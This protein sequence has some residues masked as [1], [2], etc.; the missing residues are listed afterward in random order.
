M[1]RLASLISSERIGTLCDQLRDDVRSAALRGDVER[2]RAIVCCQ[3]HVDAQ[4]DEAVHQLRAPAAARSVKQCARCS[5]V[6]VLDVDPFLRQERLDLVLVPI[7]A[8]RVKELIV[9]QRW[10]QHLAESPIVEEGKHGTQLVWDVAR[11][12]TEKE[13]DF[14]I[15]G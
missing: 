11:T 4:P 15:E 10:R 14:F 6:A 13:R 5:A 2:R 1:R 3:P 8:R 9:R 12:H 7:A